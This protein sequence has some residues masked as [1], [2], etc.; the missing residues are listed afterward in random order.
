MNN[1]SQ[2]EILIV[3]V[4]FLVLIVLLVVLFRH[5]PE[6]RIII[7]NDT[8]LVEVNESFLGVRTQTHNCTQGIYP[9]TDCSPGAILN[10]TAK[11]ICYSGYSDS[12]RDVSEKTKNEVYASYDVYN[13]EPYSYEIDHLVPLS[14]GG[15]NDISN[16]FPEK[17]EMEL[18]ARTKDKVENCFHRMVCNYSLDLKQAQ[19]IMANNWT[20]GLD[21]CGIQVK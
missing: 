20:Q 10:V 17:Y 6:T 11:D 15:S 2:V 14:I 16:L 18:G 19:S 1:R 4:V 3:F 12:V 5:P 7:I 8:R 21:M 9:D 13:R